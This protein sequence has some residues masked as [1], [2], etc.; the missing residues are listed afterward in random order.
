[1]IAPKSRPQAAT[2][3]HTPCPNCDHPLRLDSQLHGH[4]VRC[5]ACDSV[6]AV[7]SAAGVTGG[8]PGHVDVQSLAAR[9][10]CPHCHQRL[11]LTPDLHDRRIR[12][13]TCQTVLRIRLRP[14]PLPV[15][16]ADPLADCDG[17]VSSRLPNG[18][19]GEAPAEP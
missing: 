2:V 4:R 5:L 14:A 13:R 3:V 1:M 8:E 18:R 16:A 7:R 9:A 17:T 6:L 15:C 12:C 19:E 10:A 11:Q